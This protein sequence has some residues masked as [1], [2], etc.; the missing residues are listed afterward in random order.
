MELSP[1]AQLVKKKSQLCGIQRFSS[2]FLTACHWTTAL[3]Q[4]SPFHVLMY[5]VSLKIC[6]IVSCVLRLIINCHHWLTL[7]CV[8]VP[9]PT[10]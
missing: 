1:V 5:H 4:M 7:L 9:H 3:R 2:V 8:P 10:L 6:F